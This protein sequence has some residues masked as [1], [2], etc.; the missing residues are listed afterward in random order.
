MRQA[1]QGGGEQFGLG[2]GAWQGEFIIPPE[3][4]C[5]EAKAAAGRNLPES[6]RVRG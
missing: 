5:S 1:V 3:K 4:Q 2:S 6:E